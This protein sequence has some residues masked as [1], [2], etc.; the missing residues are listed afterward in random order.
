[1]LTQ[2]Y[3]GKVPTSPTTTT[4]T[5]TTSTEPPVPPSEGGLL[6]GGTMSIF[7]GPYWVIRNPFKTYD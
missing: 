1:M 6:S 5:T 2:W 7:K 3:I 4:T